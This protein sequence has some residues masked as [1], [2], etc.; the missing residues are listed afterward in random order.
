MTAINLGDAPAGGAGQPISL[1]DTLPQGVTALEVSGVAGSPLADAGEVDCIL[2]TVRSVSCIYEASLAPYDQIEVRIRVELAPEG[3]WAAEE[4]R[5]AV[6]GGGAP[7]A[8]LD[9]KLF[10]PADPDQLGI[11]EFELRP[12][13]EGGA[14]TTRA[15]SHPFQVTAAFSLAQ[16]A[17]AMP[18]ALPKD[19][20]LRLPPGL[21]ADA[22]SVL[23]CPLPSFHES[24]CSPASVVGVGTFAVNEPAQFGVTRLVAPIFNLEPAPGQPARFGSL[25]LGLPV[26]INS[27]LRSDDYSAELAIGNISQIAGFLGATVTLWGVPGDPRQDDSRGLDCLM[28]NRGVDEFSCPRLEDPDPRAM[29]TMPTSCD[30]PPPQSS[31]VVAPWVDPLRPVTMSRAFPQV[32]GCEGVPFQPGAEPTTS[33]TVASSSSGFELRLDMPGIGLR[34]PEGIGESALRSVEV[35]LPEGVTINPSAAN[36]LSSCSD[37]DYAS[38]SIRS[39]GCPDASKLGTVAIESPIFAGPLTG[40]AYLGSAGGERFDGSLDLL[41]VARNQSRG[42]LVKL[43]AQLRLD[44][45]TGRVAVLAD[46]LPQLPLSSLRLTF[47]PGPRAL[48]ATPSRCGTSSIETVLTPYSSPA[49]AIP[50]FSP[51]A[52]TSGSGGAPCPGAD[53]PFHPHLEAGTLNNAATRYSPLY[54]RVTRT[55][56]EGGLAGLSLALPA[57]LSARLAGL[58]TCASAALAAAAAKT[59]A[60]E[61]AAPSCP[62]GAVIGRTLVG[63]GVGPV[64][65]EVRG[66]L[67]LAD[68]YQGAPFSLAAVIPA[69]LGPLDLGTIVRRF[70][71][72]VDPRT[73]RLRV[74][75][76]EGGRLPATI[77]G[78]A[79][80]LRDLRLY[81]DRDRFIVNPSSCEP[82]AIRGHAHALD[83]QAA[84]LA[85]RFQAADCAPLP[86]RPSLSLRLTGAL[87]RNGHPG[88][89]ATIRSGGREA[90]LAAVRFT[91]PPGQLLDFH[92][93]RALCARALPARRCPAGS[94]LGHAQLLSPLLDQPLRGPIYLRRPVRGLPD[95]VA[96]LR[97]GGIRIVLE[98]HTAAASG[99]LRISFPS[100]PDLPLSRGSIV[101]QG[102]RRGLLANSENLCRH[103][104]RAEASLISHSGR[105]RW[106]RPRLRLGDAC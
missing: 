14:T 19:L 7:P 27:S 50:T 48:L 78:I 44:P 74:E 45:R 73:G 62:P 36:G 41:L 53:L 24:G 66:R 47:P 69:R 103:P 99:R 96:D 1:T 101:L 28:A 105:N 40:S 67:Y 38:E 95:L 6:T 100:L 63:V 4:N 76:G 58:E 51:F 92:H 89:R 88:L 82:A 43:R 22:G 86:F 70:P 72:D 9:R 85:E 80:H 35:S 55:D 91:L 15:G 11:E 97:S 37:S 81:F 30:D 90:H 26:I 77:D 104:R 64:L 79:L 83:G 65:S 29:L 49:A 56:G 39:H 3:L 57:G 10:G 12:E 8:A 18:T 16:T 17:D 75:L 102:G 25:P 20:R 13:E 106:S 34:S 98:G 46:R 68:P 42:L 32:S 52:V 60:A 94:R 61:A 21:V 5:M 87:G 33:S 71:V 93:L 84:S 59:A 54:V 23:A 31:I 2:Q